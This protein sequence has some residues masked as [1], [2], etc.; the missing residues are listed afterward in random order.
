MAKLIVKG[1]QSG[2]KPK[3]LKRRKTV[4][5]GFFPEV[6]TVDEVATLLRITKPAVYNLVRDG[7][8]PALRVGLKFRFY[9]EAI[10]DA[11]SKTPERVTK[12]RKAKK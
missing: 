1:T 4:D 9:R 12:E 8:L 3:L 10:F 5:E 7:K 6:L 11:M 2:N